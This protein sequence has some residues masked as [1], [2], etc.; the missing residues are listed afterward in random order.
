M[1][2]K[3]HFERRGQLLTYSDDSDEEEVGVAMAISRAA[4]CRLRWTIS[5]CKVF[6]TILKVRP[7]EWFRGV[8]PNNE[9]YNVYCMILAILIP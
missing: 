7:D 8:I 4:A 3:P 2:E 1:I 9:T 6:H 5:Q